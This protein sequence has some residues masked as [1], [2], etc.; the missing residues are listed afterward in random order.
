MFDNIHFH[1][2]NQAELITDEYIPEYWYS[3]EDY[4]K[5]DDISMYT[6]AIDADYSISGSVFF[7]PLRPVSPF[8][9]E[10][11][12]YLMSFGLIQSDEK[13]YTRR[14]NYDSYL[15]LFTY[16]GTGYL[17]YE[18]REYYLKEGDGVFI[19]C[20]KPHFYRSDS[21]LW[22]HSVLH[23]NGSMANEL[24][25]MFEKSGS[26]LFCS[27]VVRSYQ[28]HMEKLLN[29][30]NT[31]PPY[32]ELQ[33]S[34]EIHQILT[35]I[36]V[37]TDNK[38]SNTNALSENMRYLVKYMENNYNSQ[39]SLDYLAKF[40]NISKYHLCREF[41]KYTGFSPNEYLIRLRIEHAKFYLHNT[42]ISVAKIA[43]LVGIPDENNFIYHFKKRE[44]ITPGRFRT[45]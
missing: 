25:K 34:N 12:F 29:I 15:I 32:M 6:G 2:L 36:I 8:A 22:Y 41:K 14:E 23:F 39:M 43:Q 11:Y 33:I 16:S 30:Y 17:E 37:L 19:D 9:M 3:F 38:H 10:H 31:A 42:S 35:E 18:G 20:R 44:G 7:L 4:H 40:S 5:S 45:K 27:S 13:Y 24:F 1:K 21:E 28:H 26:V